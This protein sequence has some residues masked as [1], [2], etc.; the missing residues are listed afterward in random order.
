[1]RISN[2]RISSFATITLLL[3]PAATSAGKWGDDVSET[4]DWNNLCNFLPLLGANGTG[5][6]KTCSS[7]RPLNTNGGSEGMYGGSYYTSKEAGTTPARSKCRDLT[8]DAINA[9]GPTGDFV[10]L[11]NYCTNGTG[12]THLKIY[13]QKGCPGLLSRPKTMIYDV[14]SSFTEYFTTGQPYCIS[15]GFKVKSFLYLK[16]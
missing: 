6:E 9:E 4:M 3:L 7:V 15:P 8:P 16:P 2:L 1:M 14:V 5:P 11:Y 13:D 10:V 12:W